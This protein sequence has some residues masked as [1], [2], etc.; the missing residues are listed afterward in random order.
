MDNPS[1]F[2]RPLGTMIL[3]DTQ[4]VV[5]HAW[6]AAH[7]YIPFCRWDLGSPTS[8]YMW[9]SDISMLNPASIKKIKELNN[10]IRRI[11]G[12]HYSLKLQMISLCFSVFFSLRKCFWIKD[13]GKGLLW[14]E[15][16][17]KEQNRRDFVTYIVSVKFYNN[18]DHL[19]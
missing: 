18:Y 4:I 7:I 1:R 5:V 16:M 9:P 2:P 19:R 13:M 11:K 15:N 14:K 3:G 10:K 17:V 12:L 6:I 8:T